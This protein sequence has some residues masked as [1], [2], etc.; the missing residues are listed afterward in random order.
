MMSSPHRSLF[1]ESWFSRGVFEG[2]NTTL[3]GEPKEVLKKEGQLMSQ[4]V[5]QLLN[6]QRSGELF[7]PG[8]YE[9]YA[10]CQQ[11][12]SRSHAQ[13]LQDL[14]VLY[15]LKEKRDGFFVEF[16]ACD[17]V[18]LSNTLL[19]ERDYGWNGI[20]AEPNPFWHKA[21]AENRSCCIAHSCV[22]ARSGESIVF[23]HI[24]H[25]P[26][27]S[28]VRE[29]VPDDVHE[30]NGNRAYK[31]EI[32]VETTSLLD[33]LRAHDAPQEIDYLS[34]D[35]EGSELTILEAF[36][37]TAYT[38]HLISVEHAGEIQKRESIRDLL[39]AHDYSRWRPELSRW[40]D[41]YLRKGV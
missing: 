21:L 19:L 7:N 10:F 1:L 26:E 37:F 3:H 38:F 29:I 22:T 25:M 31:E 20:L 18:E 24:P 12:L 27:L 4:L 28:R 9:F 41:W 8:L 23:A 35:T 16:G 2:L 34:I 36:D 39:E 11:H 15:M 32:E 13:I 30:K 14:W 5:L 40:D 17:G 6:W 33:L